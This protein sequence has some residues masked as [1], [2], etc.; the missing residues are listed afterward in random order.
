MVSDD[1][2]RRRHILFT[3]LTTLSFCY[4]PGHEP[5]LIAALR[6]QLGG[7][8]GI[9]RIDAGHGRAS[10]TTSSSRATATRTGGR[11]ST[12]PGSATR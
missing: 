3:M 1:L 11:R 5:P 9:G 12:P 6:Q 7:C 10:S 4:P 8:P 2:P